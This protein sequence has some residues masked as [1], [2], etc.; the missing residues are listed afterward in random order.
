MRVLGFRE[1]MQV[2]DD[3]RQLSMLSSNLVS[4]G[5]AVDEL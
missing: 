1:H 2:G 5:A 3:R 4:H